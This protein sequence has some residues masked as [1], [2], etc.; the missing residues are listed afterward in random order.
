MKIE[1]HYNLQPKLTPVGYQQYHWTSCY[2]LKKNSKDNIKHVTMMLMLS[3]QRLRGSR[4]GP[5]SGP[6]IPL[7]GRCR[8]WELVTP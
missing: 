4:V 2:S 1:H 5:E 7:H 3:W 6:W 8:T